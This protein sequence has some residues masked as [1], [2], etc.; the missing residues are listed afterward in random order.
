[1]RMTEMKNEIDVHGLFPE[2]QLVSDERLR[3]AVVTIWREL[4]ALSEF[5]VLES[6]PVSAN[7]DYPQIKHCQ[8]IVRAALAVAEAWESVHDVKFDRDVL[9]AGALLMDV[10][11]FVEIRPRPGGG[12]EETPIGRSLPHAFFAAHRALELEVPL[13]VVHIMTTHS[14]S[15]GKAPNTLECHLLDWIDQ[16]DISAFG[17]EIWARKVFHFLSV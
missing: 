2:L 16:A 5:D 9:I 11:K 6:V 14:P 4:W 10:S 3:D 15:S 17:R 13:P 12:Y 7:I 1:M 8:G